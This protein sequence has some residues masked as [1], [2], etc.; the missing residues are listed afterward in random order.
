M[1][2]CCSCLLARL[3]RTL[4]KPTGCLQRITMPVST[5]MLVLDGNSD[6]T[7]YSLTL[8]YERNMYIIVTVCPPPTHLG[9]LGGTLGFR[10]SKKAFTNTRHKPQHGRYYSPASSVV[11]RRT[12]NAKVSRSSRLWGTEAVASFLPVS[13]FYVPY[14]S[15]RVRAVSVQE[16]VSRSCGGHLHDAEENEVDNTCQMRINS[17]HPPHSCPP[18]EDAPKSRRSAPN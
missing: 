17:S 10:I 16:Q 5:F 4:T 6:L 2:S 12:R 15:R 14:I 18:N 13:M 7:L 3:A 11:E 1:I 8:C 9:W